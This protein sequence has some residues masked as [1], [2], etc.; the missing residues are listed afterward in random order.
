MWRHF[1]KSWKFKPSWAVPLTYDTIDKVKNVKNQILSKSSSFEQIDKYLDEMY[2]NNNFTG[3]IYGSYDD[4]TVEAEDR[5]FIYFLH[6]PKT[7]GQTV[8]SLFADFFEKDFIRLHKGR[9]GKKIDDGSGN[10]DNKIPMSKTCKEFKACSAYKEGN[11]KIIPGRFDAHFVSNGVVEFFKGN[12]I[13]TRDYINGFDFFGHGDISIPYLIYP[14][15][16]II[17]TFLRDPINRFYSLYNFLQSHMVGTLDCVDLNKNGGLQNGEFLF[18]NTLKAFIPANITKKEDKKRY[19]AERLK[20]K[21]IDTRQ[22]KYQTCMKIN[23]RDIIEH[24][25]R[26]EVDLYAMKLKFIEKCRKHKLLTLSSVPFNYPLD[27]FLD[28]IID[29]EQDNFMTRAYSGGTVFSYFGNNSNLTLDDMIKLSKKAVKNFAFIGFSEYFK[30]SIEL[31]LSSFTNVKYNERVI[32]RFF[33]LQRNKS[34]NPNKKDSKS[35]PRFN[36]RLIKV[37][38][39][40]ALLYDYAI[41]IFHKRYDNLIK[42]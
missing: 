17:V 3:E 16:P 1:P 39:Y 29:I 31:F 2:E 12:S 40:D 10:I 5:D 19:N 8:S 32:K 28:I 22:G 34:S 37:E 35:D 36:D 9:P 30:E 11:R 20:R 7:G 21:N 18:D 25:L 38:K 33:N 27:D 24:D 4:S 6:I 13:Y 26:K 23:S 15:R 42:R 41:E 14:R